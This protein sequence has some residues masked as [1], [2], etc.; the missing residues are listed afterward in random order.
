MTP[1]YTRNYVCIVRQG[2]TKVLGFL[3]ETEFFDWKNYAYRLRDS[4][5]IKQLDLEKMPFYK[6]LK[7]INENDYEYIAKDFHI[8]YDLICYQLWF[9]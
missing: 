6:K 3:V 8:E 7:L 1:S 4:N 5:I 2:D 9:I